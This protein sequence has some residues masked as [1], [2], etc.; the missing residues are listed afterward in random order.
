MAAF[1]FDEV[2]Y[3]RYDGRD[4]VAAGSSLLAG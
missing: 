4:G 3:G 2:R 1:S